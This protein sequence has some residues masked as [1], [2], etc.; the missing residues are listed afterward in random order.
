MRR[1]SCVTPSF[2]AAGRLDEAIPFFERTFDDREQV[3][4]PTHPETLSSGN[5]LA[6]AYRLLNGQPRQALP[7]GSSPTTW[8]TVA[9]H[10][11]APSRRAPH[12]GSHAPS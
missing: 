9:S 3:L 8:R 6:D 1:I 12:G 10:L 7:P 2:A 5:K 4:G 11:F